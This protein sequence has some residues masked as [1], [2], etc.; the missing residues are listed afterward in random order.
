MA[1]LRQIL[2]SLGNNGPTQRNLFGPVDREQLQLEYQESLR[3][4]L[5]DASRRWGFDF[6]SEKPIDGGDF[7]WEGISGSKVPLL[8]RGACGHDD[9]GDLKGQMVVEVAAN[10][11]PRRQKENIP[12]TPKK[13]VFNHQNPE[14][15][16]RKENGKLKRKQTN[17][18]DFY[19][20]KR[21]TGGIIGMPLGRK[22]G[23]YY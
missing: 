6:F 15:T 8:Y 3:K 10:S 14:K 4:D 23:Q 18:T 22:S 12:R 9:Q 19:P 20:A 13:C 11:P 16:P 21:R 7:Q 5:E 1:S 17:I 2:R